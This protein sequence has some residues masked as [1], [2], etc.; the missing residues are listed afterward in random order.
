MSQ[1]LASV[2]QSEFVQK[3][4]VTETKRKSMEVGITSIP[5]LFV[6]VVLGRKKFVIVYKYKT[7]TLKILYILHISICTYGE[8]GVILCTR[9]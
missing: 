2:L 9:L 4:S 1:G 3:L 8:K 6:E 7:R 5:F